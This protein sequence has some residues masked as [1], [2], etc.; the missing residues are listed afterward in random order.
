[1]STTILHQ[2]RWFS[3]RQSAAGEEFLASRDDEV[4][5]V[6]LTA[7][8]EVLLS[9]EPSVAFGAPTLILPS[10][11]VEPNVANA[12]QANRELQEEIGY[13]A[14]QIDFLGELQPWSK[15]LAVRSFV[16]LGRDLS[17]SKLAG[18]EGYAIEVARVPLDGFEALI[19]NGRLR[20]ARVIAALFLARAFL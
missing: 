20:D 10:G 7:T 16:Y 9:I 8:G 4:L 17:E 5:V 2:T 15:Y 12:E 3:I 19:A 6:P 13:R 14:G 11:Q 1:M 18:D